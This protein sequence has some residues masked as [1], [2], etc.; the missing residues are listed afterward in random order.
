M[1]NQVDEAQKS[2]LL[3]SVLASFVEVKVASEKGFTDL[4]QIHVKVGSV[5]V[6]MP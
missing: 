6:V 3:E 4:S 1:S 2:T 5:P